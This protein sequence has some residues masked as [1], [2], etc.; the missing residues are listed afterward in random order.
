MNREPCARCR[1][2]GSK[3]LCSVAAGAGTANTG[4][5]NALNVAGT[6]RTPIGV[7]AQFSITRTN[8][9]DSSTAYTE[10]QVV[11]EGSNYGVGDKIIISGSS[12]GGTT[13]ANDVTVQIQSVSSFGGAL[14]NTH[15]GTAVGG[16]GLSVYSSVTT[17]DPVSQAIP[18]SST[19]SY[20]ALA[21][22]SAADQAKLVAKLNETS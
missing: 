17:S 11:Q 13:P 5:G 2:H 9:T 19:I 20:S 12:L 10:C 3:L 22:M 8:D 15:S 16:T 21:T 18:L 1:H 4:T 6:N 14:S 7:G